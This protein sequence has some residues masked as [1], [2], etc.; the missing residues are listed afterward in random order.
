MQKKEQLDELLNHMLQH[1]FRITAQRKVMLDLILRFER[2]FTAMEL[3]QTMEK[4]FQGLSYGT[5]YQNLKLYSKLRF[6]E[7]FAM[8]NEV[9]YRFIDREQPQFHFI[10]MDCEKTI[11]VDF[12]PAQVEL[13]LPQRF[14]LVNYQLDV[15]GYCMECSIP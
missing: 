6:I 5:V 15:F 12:N 4:E 3:H 2:P 8:A 13:P 11:M 9:R 14:H 10:C 1:G 7:T